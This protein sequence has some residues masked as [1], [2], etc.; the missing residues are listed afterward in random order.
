MQAPSTRLTPF[1]LFVA[2]LLPCVM[3]ALVG[4]QNQKTEQEREAAMR[5]PSPAYDTSAPEPMPE[6]EPMSDTASEQPEPAPSETATAQ[7]APE[8]PSPAQP[9]PQGSTYTIRKGDTLWSI[10]QREY[11]DGQR[12]VDIV[13]ANP[14]IEPKKLRVG[15]TITLP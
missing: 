6:P 10:A 5:V 14:G 7:P 9:A 11:G 13:R 8:Q 2:V 1:E 4:C 3:F 12:W 15:Q